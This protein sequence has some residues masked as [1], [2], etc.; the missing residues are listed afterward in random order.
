MT[1]VQKQR[2]H[3]TRRAKQRY[4]LELDKSDI[5]K[6]INLIQNRGAVETKKLTN[7]RTLHVIQY[8]EQELKV[9]YDKKRHNVCTFMPIE[10]AGA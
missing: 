1:R 5:D 2:I 3:A 9:I 4:G 7:A 6:I 8:K 10:W